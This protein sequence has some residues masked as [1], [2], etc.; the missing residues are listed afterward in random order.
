MNAFTT[1][2]VTAYHQTVPP[3]YVDLAIRLE[4]ERMRGLR[5]SRR[6]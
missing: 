1:E 2:D 3:S 4:A 6:P 5:C